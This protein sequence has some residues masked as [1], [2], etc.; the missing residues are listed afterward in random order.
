MAVLDGISWKSYTW[1]HRSGKERTGRAIGFCTK[2]AHQLSIHHQSR[3][4]EER[5]LDD[6]LELVGD[7]R[8]PH[9]GG[10][11]R[12]EHGTR[13]AHPDSGSDH[14][15][16]ELPEYMNNKK[17]PRHKYHRNREVPAREDGEKPGMRELGGERWPLKVRNFSV[18][19]LR[20]PVS[21]LFR[22]T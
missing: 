14:V 17:V 18:E 8:A 13:S 2:E 22:V 12:H 6:L 16:L 7:L 15:G 11:S 5:I 20:F 4:R 9:G 21:G 3:D 19:L 10:A 1:T